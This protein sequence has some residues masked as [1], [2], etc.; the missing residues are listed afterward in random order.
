MINL[1]LNF[2][3]LTSEEKFSKAINK[4]INNLLFS[5]II[6][7]KITNFKNYNYSNLQKSRKNP[8]LKRNK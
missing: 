7:N 4:M 3:I 8:N 5:Y 2:I 6:T 1:K